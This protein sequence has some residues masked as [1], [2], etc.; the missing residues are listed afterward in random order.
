MTRLHESY[1]SHDPPKTSSARAF[2]FVFAA[3]L[4][5]LAIGRWRRGGTSPDWFAAASVAVAL[6]AVVRP[7]FLQPLNK[8]WL[9]LGAVLHRLVSPVV[10]AILFYGIVTPIGVLMRLRGKDPLRLKPSPGGSS[11]W[12]SRD[13]AAGDHFTNQF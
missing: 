6:V 7:A 11:Y 5:L 8:R 2:G 4:A 10:L 9:A 13:A 1:V 12:L 3:L